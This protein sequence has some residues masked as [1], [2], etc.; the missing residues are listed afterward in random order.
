VDSG[1][2]YPPRQQAV[3]TLGG[4]NDVSELVHAVLTGGT[5]MPVPMASVSIA[6]SRS[7]P[8]GPCTAATKQEDPSTKGYPAG[9]ANRGE[10]GPGL[11][12]DV[13]EIRH[14]HQY[15]GD[16]GDHECSTDSKVGK[17]CHSQ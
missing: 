6:I 14:R 12:V 2:A 15:C 17:A 4:A 16:A 10:N 13:I 9:R 1:R 3:A 8:G 11:M 7:G 5:L